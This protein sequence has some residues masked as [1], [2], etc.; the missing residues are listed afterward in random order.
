MLGFSLAA[1]LLGYVKLAQFLGVL[2]LYSTFIA[3]SMF[4][5]VRVFT[6][7]L[8]EALDTPAA[9][10]LAMVEHCDAIV[11]GCRASSNGLE[12]YL[13]VGDHQSAGF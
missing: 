2:C 5:C 6:R 10:Q 7:L 8:L 9:Q 3:V 4:T 11:P 12:P 13:A 1:K